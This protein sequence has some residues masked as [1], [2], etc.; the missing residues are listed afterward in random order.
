MK[1]P[2]KT[3]NN[4]GIRVAGDC[5]KHIPNA[6]DTS[7]RA[8]QT[9]TKPPLLRHGG[10]TASA[11]H[12]ITVAVPT[13][14]NQSDRFRQVLSTFFYRFTLS[15]RAGNLRTVSDEPISVPFHDGREFVV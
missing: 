8:Q 5:Q 11:R 4:E 13:L 14:Q 2:G 3:G 12:R 10:L 6:H 7:E 15:V 9:P 1:P